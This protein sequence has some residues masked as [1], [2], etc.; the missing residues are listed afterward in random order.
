MAITR[1]PA[2]DLLPTFPL[3]YPSSSWNYTPFSKPCTSET[4]A[5]CE[6][7]A[8]YCTPPL[9]NTVLEGAF[10]N[11]CTDSTCLQFHLILTG[12]CGH[13]C[14]CTYPKDVSLAM[15]LPYL[16]WP[17]VAFP[18]AQEIFRCF[19]VNQL[20]TQNLQGDNLNVVSIEL[21]MNIIILITMV[22][23]LSSSYDVSKILLADMADYLIARTKKRKSCY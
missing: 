1:G 19:H 10:E 20:A 13:L 7:D 15:S 23:R 3:P 6:T 18:L 17:V 8:K 14:M 16:S 4:I 5:V 2:C 22:V 11:M 21:R 9:Q 12:M